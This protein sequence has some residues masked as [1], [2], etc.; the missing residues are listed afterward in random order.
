MPTGSG[1]NQLFEQGCGPA[2]ASPLFVS[3]LGS[4][5][6]AQRLAC[7]RRA[8]AATRHSIRDLSCERALPGRTRERCRARDYQSG[9][10]ERRD[11]RRAGPRPTLPDLAGEVLIVFCLV[12]G[13]LIAAEAGFVLLIAAS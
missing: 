3:W 12:S 6:G 5:R 9:A 10:P 7:P 11:T 1:D 13:L 2:A 4:R 8:H